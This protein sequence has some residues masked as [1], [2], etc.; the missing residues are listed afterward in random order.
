MNKECPFC[1]KGV[2]ERKTIKETYSYKGHRL[3]IEQRI[4]QQL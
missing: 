3:E 2:L 1:K 4:L